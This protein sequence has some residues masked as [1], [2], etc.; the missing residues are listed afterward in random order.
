[1]SDKI[2]R[3]KGILKFMKVGE[4]LKKRSFEECVEL[5][6]N[7]NSG[8]G[9]KIHLANKKALVLLHVEESQKFALKSLTKAKK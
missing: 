5:G 4:N 9:G 6:L 3:S 1:M 8:E 7:P 2:T